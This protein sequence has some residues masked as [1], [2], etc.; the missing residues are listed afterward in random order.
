[1]TSGS[2]QSDSSIRKSSFREVGGKG[3][4]TRPGILLHSIFH[5]QC[6]VPQDTKGDARRLIS[7]YTTTHIE[8]K[9]QGIGRVRRMISRRSSFTVNS[10]G[11]PLIRRTLDS[12]H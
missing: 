9:M 2:V 5:T 10:A 8:V 4:R 11:P 1:M 6:Q 12:Y 7:T 3:S